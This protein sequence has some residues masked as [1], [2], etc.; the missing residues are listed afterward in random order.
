MSDVHLLENEQLSNA[1]SYVNELLDKMERILHEHRRKNPDLYRLAEERRL[2]KAAKQSAIVKSKPVVAVANTCGL[3]QEPLYF[4]Q[5]EQK[6]LKQKIAVNQNIIR[7]QIL[8]TQSV[9]VPRTK[10]QN[11]KQPYASVGNRP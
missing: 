7:E 8:A 6:Q 3:K 2:I 4:K 9:L 11:A 10:A 1:T 5:Y